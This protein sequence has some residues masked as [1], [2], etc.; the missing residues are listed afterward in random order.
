MTVLLKKGRVFLHGISLEM[1]NHAID[2]RQSRLNLIY[3]R[4]R[5]AAYVSA[6]DTLELGLIFCT[7]GSV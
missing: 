5:F 1:F 6:S 7:C 3:V 2:C 4:E